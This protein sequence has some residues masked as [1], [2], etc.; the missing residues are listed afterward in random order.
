MKKTYILTLL[1]MAI[2]SGYILLKPSNSISVEDENA[3]LLYEEVLKSKNLSIY[4]GNKYFTGNSENNYIMLDDDLWRIIYIN[5]NNEI[6]LIKNSKITTV[7]STKYSSKESFEYKD[8]IVKDILSEWYE[9]KLSFLKDYI[10]EDYYCS[11][12]NKTCLSTAKAN[13]GII[14]ENEYRNTF[15]KGLS[16]LTNSFDWWIISNNMFEDDTYYAS[17]VAGDGGIIKTSIDDMAG[18]RPVITINGKIKVTGKGTINEPY[19]I[20]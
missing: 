14:A 17:F 20:N 6:K 4:D 9:N 5:D 13:I 1:L 11:A 8:S 2:I 15:S 16:F 7:E 18:I 3:S 19:F 10:I 12:Y